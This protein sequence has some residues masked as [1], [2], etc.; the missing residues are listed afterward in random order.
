MDVQDPTYLGTSCP[1]LTINTHNRI[2]KKLIKMTILNRRSMFLNILL[3]LIAALLISQII[4]LAE[5]EGF[6]IVSAPSELIQHSDV[7]AMC[8]VDDSEI[9]KKYCIDIVAWGDHLPWPNA[10]EVYNRQK[11]FKNA[12]IS[13]VRYHSIDIALMQEGKRYLAKSLGRWKLPDI[14]LLNEKDK[15]LVKEHSVLDINKNLTSV[16]WH[17]PPIACIH[18][19]GYRKWMLNRIDWLMK[20][21]PGA[22]HFDEPLMGAACAIFSRNPGCFCDKCCEEFKLYLKSRPDVVWK[23]HGIDSLNEFNYRN[24]IK[25]KGVTPKKA[26]LWDEFVRFQILSAAKFIEELKK[27]AELKAATPFL[28]STNA[29]PSSWEKLPFLHLM[30]YISAELS[31]NG[32]YLKVPDRPILN[33][34]LGDG[35]MKPVFSTALGSDWAQIKKTSHTLLACSWIAQA[36]AYGHQF[37]MPIRAFAKDSFYYPTTDHY[38]CMANWIKEVK[39]LLDDYESLSNTAVVVS[40]DSFKKEKNKQNII[41]L[42]SQ[43]SYCKIP[44][45]II[46]KGNVFFEKQISEKDFEGCSQIIVALPK[47]FSEDELLLI[48]KFSGKNTVWMADATA[49]NNRTPLKFINTPIE[50]PGINDVFVI[51]RKK[52]TNNN[53]SSFVLHLLNREYDA[54]EYNMEPKGPFKIIIDSRLLSGSNISK[55]VLHQ[56]ILSEELLDIILDIPEELSVKQSSNEIEII[57][58]S[59]ELWG[60][61]ELQPS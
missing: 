35:L 44:F 33:Y 39:C 54:E 48:K 22:L 28:F 8:N 30:D 58:P 47:F 13:G 57:I 24:F 5:A 14:K 53:G 18:D 25:S 45:H 52:I 36:Y 27:R 40:L 15:H 55:A 42:C 43:L 34:K 56:P 61:I 60:I 32:K 1:N 46:I 16:S 9:L 3:L 59:L 17:K 50:T 12:G 23:T 31:H 10:K 21:N 6:Q 37:M 2:Q 11:I 4:C 51:P 26:P 41:K 20:T 49:I 7:V 38:A 19:V 29:P